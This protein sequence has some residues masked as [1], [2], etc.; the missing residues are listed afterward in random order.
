MCNLQ[1]YQ[2]YLRVHKHRDYSGGRDTG[3]HRAGA[4]CPCG[5]EPLEHISSPTSNP[6]QMPDDCRPLVTTTHTDKMN[7]CCHLFQPIDQIPNKVSPQQQTNKAET[8]NSQ[9]PLLIQDFSAPITAHMLDAQPTLSP[10]LNFIHSSGR[11]E[12]LQF[13]SSTSLDQFPAFVKL[14]MIT[15]LQT[16]INIDNLDDFIDVRNF[17]SS[18]T[19]CAYPLSINRIRFGPQLTL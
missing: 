18:D 3:R 13:G 5:S 8:S 1:L 15:Q 16:H 7:S 4:C 19:I 12:L 2:I 9:N 17:S 10:L 6:D 11:D 14:S